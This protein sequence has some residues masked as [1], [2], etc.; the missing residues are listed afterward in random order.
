M[1]TQNTSNKKKK[2]KKV[3]FAVSLK[4]LLNEIM[5]PPTE[6]CTQHQLA[7]PLKFRQINN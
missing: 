2:S 4:S 6:P 3:I 1:H 5:I 7:K